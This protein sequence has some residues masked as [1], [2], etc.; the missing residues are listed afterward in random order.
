M[1]ILPLPA[2]P[3]ASLS[4]DLVWDGLTGDLAPALPS[5][6][7]NMGGLR[8]RA[9]IATA[10]LI[11]LM[12]DVRADPTEL[13]DGDV[14]RGW[15]GDG[16]DLRGYETPLG[17]KL[18]LLR[19]RTVDD[20]ETPRLAEDYALEAL[21]PLLA[22]GVAARAAADATADPARNRLILDVALYG[23]DGVTVYQAR[24]AVLWE[25]LNGLPDPLAP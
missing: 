10:V 16:F 9:A 18:W 21:Q 14:N 5:E 19:R 3:E 2:A 20:V 1:R 6:A 12:T 25:Q 7:E 17:S 8:A 4:P 15:P 23:R 22:Q 13:R 24:Y 11:A